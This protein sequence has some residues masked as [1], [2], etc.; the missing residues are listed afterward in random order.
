MSYRREIPKGSSA[1]LE[2]EIWFD[3]EEYWDYVYIEVS[4]DNGE[5]WEIIETPK[6]SSENPLGNAFGAGYTGSSGG[7]L[8][9]LIELTP[10]AGETLR[11]R[12]Q[13][14]TDD[15]VNAAGACFRDLSV[16]PAAIIDG[17]DDW[18]PHGFVFTN[19]VI[20]Q[21][22]LVQLITTGNDPQVQQLYLNSD[23]SGTWTIQPTQDDEGLIVAV[24]SMAENTREFAGY[25]L[26]LSPSR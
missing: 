24:G 15:A 13:Y 14:V 22:F 18:E 10:F 3:I 7:W 23:N 2:Y 1:L 21:D 17:N 19:N 12:F 20:E 25:T 8:T 16:S 26:S 4:T 6:T 9:D 11:V 5:T